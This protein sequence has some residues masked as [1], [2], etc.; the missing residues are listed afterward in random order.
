M[1]LIKMKIF[2][3]FSLLTISFCYDR[4]K[5]LAYA[6]Q[7]WNDPNHVC[8]NYL[9]CTPWTYFG[10]EK[11]GYESHGGD[12]ANFV[13]Q[14]ILA[15]GHPPLV[16][17]GDCLGVP[18]GQEVVGASRLAKCL[19]SNKF[20]WKRKCDYHLEPPDFIQPGDVIV[21]HTT[22]CNSESAH[23]ALVTSVTDGVKVTTHSANKHNVPYTYM[24]DAKPYVDYLH[25]Q[26]S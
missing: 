26:D 14:C 12:H 17:G 2:V 16:G 9:K 15:G 22:Y 4:Q 23:A 13:S 24:M 25:F 21:Y 8:G 20:H 7:Y 3:L 11:C 18:C 10:N 5:A 1:F 19:S 6:E